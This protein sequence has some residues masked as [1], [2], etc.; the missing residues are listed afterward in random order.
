MTAGMRE[1]VALEFLND[2]CDGS[3]LI[4]FISAANLN[5]KIFS[6]FLSWQCENE[7]VSFFS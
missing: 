4:L 7:N 5:L 3:F 1:L 6:I 2:V